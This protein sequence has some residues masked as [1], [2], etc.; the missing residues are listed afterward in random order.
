M[1]TKRSRR[2]MVLEFLAWFI[3]SII[4]AVV[5]VALSDSLLPANF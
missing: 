1:M 2:S 3:V 5:L 4:T